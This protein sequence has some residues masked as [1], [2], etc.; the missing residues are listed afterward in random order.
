PDFLANR[1]PMQTR[2]HVEAYM[3]RLSAFARQMNQDTEV[4]GQDVAAGVVAPD[5][6]L[7]K[8]LV[9]LRAFARQ[10]PGDT[11]LVKSLVARLPNVTEVPE[12]QRAQI[13]AHATQIVQD[14]VMPAY[15]RQ[16]DAVAAVRRHA[17][18]DAGVWKLAQGEAMYAAAL[19]ARITVDLTPAQIHQMGLDILQDTHAQ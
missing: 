7:D 4:L 1:H 12:G 9:Q 19:K 14:E 2:D 11:E 6:A 17:T 13:V 5:F 3:A 10:A 15:Q 16:I 18:H 8:A